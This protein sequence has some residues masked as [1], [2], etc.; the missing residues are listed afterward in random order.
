MKNRLLIGASIAAIL[1]AIVYVARAWHPENNA[2]HPEGMQYICQDC[3]EAWTTSMK[4]LGEHHKAHFG[5]PLPC[6]KCGK[7]K[8][9]PAE[10]CSNCG[11]VF[12]ADRGGGGTCPKCGKSVYGGRTQG[13]AKPA[14][15]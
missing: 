9:V 12:K 3:G 15:Q 2:N 6:P 4:E 14:A 5:Q 10:K 8:T 7:T 1:V 11:T 13:L